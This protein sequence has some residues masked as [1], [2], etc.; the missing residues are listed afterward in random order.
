M[1]INPIEAL[2]KLDALLQLD[3]RHGALIDTLS[4]QVTE[5][6][7]RIAKLEAREEVLIARAEGAAAA[8]AANATVSTVTD[9]ARR[10]GGIEER[11]RS[12]DSRTPRTAQ[13]HE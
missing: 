10:L 9:L 7:E 11:V 6:R 12:L 13:E 1:A 8:S 2:R 3:V 5:L 4:Q